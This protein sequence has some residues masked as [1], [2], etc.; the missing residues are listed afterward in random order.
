MEH[1]REFDR[2][3][4]N[5]ET[6]RSYDTY[7]GFADDERVAGLFHKAVAGNTALIYI[8]CTFLASLRL[9][10]PTTQLW[11]YSLQVGFG[12]G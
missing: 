1:Y 9:I 11:R 5:I 7:Y 4:K 6:I 2:R 8:P 3:H 12:F 10:L